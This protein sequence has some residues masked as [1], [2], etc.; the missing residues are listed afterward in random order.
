MQNRCNYLLRAQ[1]SMRAGGPSDAEF[2]GGASSDD[3]FLVWRSV[4]E[5][6]CYI[7]P[8]TFPQARHQRLGHVAC[9]EAT[10][11]ADVATAWYMQS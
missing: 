2:G 10:S 5:H 11:K 6:A 8:N 7:R 9:P 1:H 4:F 3:D